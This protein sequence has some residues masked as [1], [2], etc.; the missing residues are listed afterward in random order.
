MT[1]T[2]VAR[3]TAASTPATAC[4]GAAAAYAAFFAAQAGATRGWPGA[5]G[6]PSD[7]PQQLVRRQEAGPEASERWQQGRQVRHEDREGQVAM[8]RP[9]PDTADRICRTPAECFAAGWKDGEDDRPLTQQELE[10]LT[11]LHAP[12]LRSQTEANAS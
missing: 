6:G 10:R 11:A 8:P 1:G 12:F 5:G 9:T 3:T 7:A 2:P 4:T